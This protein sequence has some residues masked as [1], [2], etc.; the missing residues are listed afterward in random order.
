MCEVVEYD[1]VQDKCPRCGEA[2]N[3]CNEDAPHDGIL[4]VICHECGYQWSEPDVVV[5]TKHVPQF[6]PTL[7]N[8]EWYYRTRMDKLYVLRVVDDKTGADKIPVW[9]YAGD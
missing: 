1:S 5:D 6:E 8:G 2:D 3:I 7:V 4:E 9:V